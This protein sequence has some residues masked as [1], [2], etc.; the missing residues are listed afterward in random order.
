[1]RVFEA[2]RSRLR[3]FSLDR[4]QRSGWF[5]LDFVAVYLNAVSYGNV[6]R[7]TED[8]LYL[9]CLLSQIKDWTY[10]YLVQ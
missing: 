2:S 6:C 10:V 5:Y 8:R 7:T 3:E 4:R 9:L 1:M